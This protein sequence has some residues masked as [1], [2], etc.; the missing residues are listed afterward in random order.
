MK[1]IVVLYHANCPDGFGAAW[2]AWKKLGNKAEYIGVSPETLPEKPLK[3][4]FIYT[5]DIAFKT[6]VFRKLMKKNKSVV[7]MDHH[8]SR[9]D[10]VKAFPQNVF[11]DNRSGA[12]LTWSYFHPGKKI[13]LLLRYIE[14]NDLWRFRLP[15]AKELSPVVFLLNFD[16]KSWSSFVSRFEDKKKR[17]EIFKRGEII[18]KYEEKIIESA[19]E[20]ATL[21]R[22]EGY[23]ALAANSAI[24]ESEIGHSLAKKL[25]P[26]GIVWRQKKEQI[27]VSLRSGGKIDVSKLAAKY[28]GGGHKNAAGFAFKA[29]RK[30]PWKIVK[31]K[32]EK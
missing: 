11:D 6:S 27:N 24:L 9:R 22:F 8:K 30:S 31:T 3:N 28:G 32:N 23:K 15:H 16:F 29:E 2:A 10:D 5:L 4:K 18:L 25:P 13:P 14:D 19:V 21:V 17:K 12:M 7:T 20:R 1:P 26:L